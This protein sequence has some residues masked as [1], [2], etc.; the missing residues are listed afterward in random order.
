LF[1]LIATDFFSLILAG[2]GGVCG[3]V[4]VILVEDIFYSYSI[5]DG[6]VRLVR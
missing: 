5:V 1:V 2:E 3:G 4:W 6:L